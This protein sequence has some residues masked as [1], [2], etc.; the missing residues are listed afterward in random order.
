MD[1]KE[2]SAIAEQPEL[3]EANLAEMSDEELAKALEAPAKPVPVADT[4]ETEV[5]ADN[6]E[7]AKEEAPE[8]S[9]KAPDLQVENA[10]LKQQLDNLKQV[11]GR[12][13]NELGELRAKLKAKPTAEDFDADPVKAA[14]QLQERT[15]QE[16]EIRKKEQEQEVHA[17]A[18]RNMQFISEHVPDLND[19]VK[20]IHAVMAEQ[21]K[22]TEDDI[23]KFTGNIYLQN[24][25]GVFQ[26]NERAKLYAE[27]KKLK[28]EIEELK[29][30]PGKVV[31]KIAD[32][33]RSAANVGASTGHSGAAKADPIGDRE[34]A[35][36]SDEALAEYLKKRKG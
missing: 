33:S 34:L 22:L 2:G 25:W 3:N 18:I 4:P 5:A 27:N 31:S 1:P 19:N 36:M 11:F 10:R 23:Q 21:D 15:E 8:K 26:L 28:A 17:I 9:E 12:Q 6:A 14:E 30:A 32:I 35:E 16:R 20:V 29:K 24:P 13:S 7:E